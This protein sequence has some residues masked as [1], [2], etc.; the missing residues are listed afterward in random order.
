[1]SDKQ[2]AK[3]R[4]VPITDLGQ[5]VYVNKDVPGIFDQAIKRGNI[6]MIPM[7][8]LESNPKSKEAPKPMFPA[9]LPVF[10][11]PQFPTKSMDEWLATNWSI[12][13]PFVPHPAIR[14]NKLL[15][16]QEEK[17]EQKQ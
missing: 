2:S 11:P 10:E 13:V 4:S 17:K 15:K 14:K 8:G 6:P 16:R 7:F 5:V 9:K 3:G 1:M 12:V